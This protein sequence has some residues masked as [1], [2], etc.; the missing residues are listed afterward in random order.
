MRLTEEKIAEIIVMSSSKSSSEMA[1]IIGCSRKTINQVLANHNIKRN[2]EVQ[3]AIRSRVR[4][5]LIRAERRRSIFGLDQKTSLKV[6]SNKERNSLKFRLRRKG[7]VFPFK[8]VNEA[9]ISFS[10]KRDPDYEERGKKLGIVFKII[11]NEKI[12]I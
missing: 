6:F 12:T 9:Y 7:Y 4:T 3:G 2:A 10:T 11:E 5:D 1:S 8:G